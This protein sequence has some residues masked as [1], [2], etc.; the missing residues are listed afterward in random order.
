MYWYN[1]FS[2]YA[3]ITG[4]VAEITKK[5]SHNMQV[6]RQHTSFKGIDTT[7]RDFM[8][9]MTRNQRINVTSAYFTYSDGSTIGPSWGTFRVDNIM[10]PQVGTRA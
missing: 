5:V 3:P 1:V 10:S 7:S 4:K 9:T 8:R 2:L 6:F